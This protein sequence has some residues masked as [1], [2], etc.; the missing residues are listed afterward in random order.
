MLPEWA[1]EYVGIPYRTRGRDRSGCDCWGLLALVFRE[2]FGWTIDGPD[3]EW[4]HGDDPAALGAGVR[5]YAS[6]FSEVRRGEERVG[7][8]VLL[9][10]RGHPLHV[11]L[12]LTP[13]WMLHT[14][15]T[16]DSCI[17]SY[18][19]PTWTNRVLGFY[20]YTP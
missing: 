10:L 11:G 17:E 16:A 19:R 8:G 5:Q 12:V 2:R 4:K 13:G 6:G 7:D 20:R 15:E 3:L 1:A 14:H 9:R 18:D